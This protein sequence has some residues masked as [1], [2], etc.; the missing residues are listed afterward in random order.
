MFHFILKDQEKYLGCTN[1]NKTR[2]SFP[3]CQVFSFHP[4]PNH[5]EK[6]SCFPH[7]PSNSSPPWKKPAAGHATPQFS[8]SLSTQLFPSELQATNP[9][10]FFWF[11]NLP[12]EGQRNSTLE[13]INRSRLRF[14]IKET[15]YPQKIL[16]W[17]LHSKSCTEFPKIQLLCCNET[18][19][20]VGTWG[21]V[22]DDRN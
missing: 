16:S 19:Y 12:E 3:L 22:N 6:H 13:D 5:A 4:T 11:T 10:T 9:L 8:C 21:W 17:T 14:K 15:V 20:R 2:W 18:T 7:K 1:Y